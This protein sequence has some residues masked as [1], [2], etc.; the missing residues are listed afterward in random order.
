MEERLRRLN[1]ELEE[2]VAE[3]TAELQAKN[4]EL[5]AFS[6]SVSHDLR[7]PLRG[8]D[9]Y[10]CLL[11][12]EYAG[13]L[14][15]EGR[16]FLET[17]RKSTDQMSQLIDDLL[18]Y[19]RIERREVQL[20]PLDLRA[21]VKALVDQ[22]RNDLQSRRIDLKID[23]PF[24]SVC[25]YA[26]GLA[27]VVRNLL[28]NAIKF[29]AQVAA[30]RI[31]IAGRET[32]RSWMLWVSDNGT[33]FDMK[34]HDRIFEIFQRLHHAEDYAGTGIGLAIVRKA[35]QRMGGRVWAE[36]TPGAGATFYLEWAKP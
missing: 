31:E 33:G 32:E 26:E 15:R 28:D 19:T 6:F 10:S 36:S 4:Q 16:F 7:T 30:P 27:Q 11:L 1:A 13:R 24:E 12:E 9:G 14:D 35:M 2:R 8:I 25:G 22:F 29:T 5:E 18:A 21:L 3:R 34:Y 20:G 23:I 17:I